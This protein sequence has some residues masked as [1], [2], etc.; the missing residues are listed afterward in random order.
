MSFT[1][2][3]FMFRFLPIFLIVYYVVPTRYKNLILLIGSFVFYA[4]GQH[5]YLLLLMLSIVVNYTFG[6]LIGERRAQRKPLLILGLIY[7]FGLLVFFKYTNFFI[8]NINALLTA[9]HVQIP[10]IS[11]VMPLGISFYTF[12]V[13]SYL[14]DVYRGDQRPVKNIINLGVYIAMFPQ[15]TS[16]PIGLYSELEPTLLRRHC[17]VLNLESGLKTFIIGMGAKMLLANP[18][19]TLWAGMSRYGY[20]T[21]SCPYA[22]LGAFGYSFQLYFDFAGY[23]LMAM[24]LGQMLGLY[25]PRNFDHPYIS[26]S[27][28]EFWRRWHMTL[29]RWFKKYLYFPLGGSRCSFAKTIRNTFVVWA[30][31][32]LWH[33]ASW[34]FVLWGLIFFVLLTIERLGLGKLLAKTKVLKHIYVIFL[35]PL[36]W[37]VFALPNMQD[38]GTYF[39]RLF[40]FFAD[41][42]ASF[43]NTKDVIRALHDYWY[44]LIACVVFCLPFPSRWY[45]KHKNSKLVIL[46]LVLIYLMSVYKMQTQTSNPFLYYQF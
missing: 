22:W 45:E 11:V 2:I 1:T 40:P 39:S 15:V 5:F 21:L 25:V 27:M 3:E 18:M 46:G 42:T 8:E 38:I 34:N 41:N 44:L 17:S 24:G 37:V 7:N 4:W 14:V 10:T 12:Q 28:A 13:V 23:S 30:F 32:G 35:I 43:V 6:R 29:G 36:T 26:G 9:T 16:G 31:T 20:E 19:G 33:G